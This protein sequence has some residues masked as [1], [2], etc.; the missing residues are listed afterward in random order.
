MAV[1][2][3]AGNDFIIPSEN[4]Q[5]YLGGAGNDT[6]ILSGSTVVANATI[7]IQDTEGTNK[8]QLVAG[9][10]ITSS[11]VTSN[12]IELTLSNNAKVQI[13]GAGSFGYDVG[14]NTL[15][16][17]VGTQQTFDTFVTSTLGTT[18]PEQ[19]DSPSTGG[20]VT[21]PEGGGGGGEDEPTTVNI[22]TGTPESPVAFNASG[23]AYEYSDDASVTTHVEISGFGSDDTIAFSNGDVDNYAFA[24]EGTDVRI[25]YNYQDEGTMNVITLTGVIENNAIV[26]DLATFTDAIGF[27]PFVV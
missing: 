3:T 21:I 12:A 23:G 8:I 10:S 22:D 7:V 25:S 20:G 2:F 15:G 26:N 9:L 16:G 5:T 6:Y 24:S 14:G 4:G 27:D 17:V 19:G 1:S 11:T 18:V 13:L